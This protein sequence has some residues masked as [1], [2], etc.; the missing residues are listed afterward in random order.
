MD[1]P[2]YAGLWHD[3]LDQL[4]SIS[5]TQSILTSLFSSLS[6]NFDAD[7][8]V[9]PNARVKA[10]ASLLLGI[11]G[12]LGEARGELWDSIASITLNRRWTEWH[13]RILVCWIAG[14]QSGDVDD[15]SGSLVVLSDCW[16]N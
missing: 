7:P 2:K 4:P 9:G 10:E 16:R 12:H 8:G 3:I 1:G 11:V 15:A 13:A 5:T 6:I 14:A